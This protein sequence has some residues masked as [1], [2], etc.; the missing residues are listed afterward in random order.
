M[1]KGKKAR[2]EE[3]PRSVSDVRFCGDCQEAYGYCWPVLDGAPYFCRCLY[4]PHQLI[5]VSEK[6]CIHFSERLPGSRPSSVTEKVSVSRDTVPL[7]RKVV[8]LFRL[9]E[10]RPWKVVDVDSIPPGGITSEG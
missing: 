1:A 10:R 4:C 3:A 2:P 6:G 9:G 5:R 8:P 7:S